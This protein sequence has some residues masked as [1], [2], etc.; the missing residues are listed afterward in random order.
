VN[1]ILV[2][3]SGAIGDTLLL[4]PLLRTLERMYPGV[5]VILSGHPERMR[6]VGIQLANASLQDFDLDFAWLYVPEASP[7]EKEAAFLSSVDWAIHFTADTQGPANANLKKTVGGRVSSVPALPPPDYPGHAAAFYF[8]TLGLEIP[9]VPELSN[10]ARFTLENLRRF[11]HPGLS[12]RLIQRLRPG[13]VVVAPGSGSPAKCWPLENWLQILESLEKKEKSFL[14]V[15][16]P[17]E[18]RVLWKKTIQPFHFGRM[19]SGLSLPDLAYLLFLA[20]SYI[21]NDSGITHLASMAAG[22]TLALFNPTDPR[23]WGPLGQLT[24]IF[25][26]QRLLRFPDWLDGNLTVQQSESI[27]HHWAAASQVI[28]WWEK[29]S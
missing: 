3:R 19:I 21:G 26:H 20:D 25:F 22:E 27:E 7:P 5:Q 2:I 12:Q 15:L 28:E 18:N 14:V 9:S 6:L 11:A 16:G 23:R 1:R 4:L 24:D 8:E 10:L 29:H 13:A 17:A